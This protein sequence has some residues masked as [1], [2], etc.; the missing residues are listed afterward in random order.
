MDCRT[1]APAA[2]LA[3][4]DGMGQSVVQVEFAENLRL[5]ELG[6]AAAQF[7]HAVAYY[8]GCGIVESDELADVWVLKSV[9]VLK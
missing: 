5:A 4:T 2:P 3:L 1:P 9:W 6:D 8:Y 7:R